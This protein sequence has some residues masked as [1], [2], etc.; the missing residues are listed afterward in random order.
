MTDLEWLK[1]NALFG[2]QFEDCATEVSYHADMLKV[3]EEKP[4]CEE[5][6]LQTNND[7][8]NTMA[9]VD[10]PEFDPFKGLTERMKAKAT[11]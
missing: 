1:K 5:C 3:W 9:W 11:G 6:Y 2:C 8:E 4:I 7:P 10:L